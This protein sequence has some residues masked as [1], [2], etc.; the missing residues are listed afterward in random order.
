MEPRQKDTLTVG[1]L[2][3]QSSIDRVV[4]PEY[5]VI[6]KEPTF[7][8][9]NKNFR[10][11]DYLYMLAVPSVLV[12]F[13][14]YKTYRHASSTVVAAGLAFPAMYGVSFQKVNLRLRGFL[15]NQP[16]CEKYQM[17]FNKVAL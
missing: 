3:G 9:V 12:S 5:P 15:E 4:L 10:A 2:A 1:Q 17:N 11:S 14:Y 7:S 16:E 6:S 8:Q 13:Y